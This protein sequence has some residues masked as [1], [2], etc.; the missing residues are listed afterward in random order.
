LEGIDEPIYLVEGNTE[1]IKI[2][3][4]SDLKYAEIYL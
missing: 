1:N 4:P 2:T 3:T